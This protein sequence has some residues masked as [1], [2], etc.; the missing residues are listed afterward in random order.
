MLS[1]G[2]AGGGKPAEDGGTGRGGVSLPRTGARDLA[3]GRAVSAAARAS[4]TPES[5]PEGLV[6]EG[7]WT[8]DVESLPPPPA[9]ETGDALAAPETRDACAGGPWGAVDAAAFTPGLTYRPPGCFVRVWAIFVFLFVSFEFC[10]DCG[11]LFSVRTHWSAAQEI[12]WCSRV[13]DNRPSLRVWLRAGSLP[14]GLGHSGD[15]MVPPSGPRA[16]P[17]P[18]GGSGPSSGQGHS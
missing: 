5:S 7:L 16:G 4:L 14:V 12:R 13:M 17:G 15:G 11:Q 8:R 10:D 3:G 9:P 18:S 2:R 1:P 6:D